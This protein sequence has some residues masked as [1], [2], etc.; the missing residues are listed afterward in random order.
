M[1][2]FHLFFGY[3]YPM[4]FRKMPIGIQDFE[5]IR[6]EGFV[7]ADKTAYV[8]RLA[9]ERKPYFLSRP[10]RFGKSLLV[11]TFKAYFEGKREIFE[12]IAGQPKLALA[13]LEQDWKPYPVFHLD[14]T[15]EA[16]QST[17]SLDSRLGSNL[18]LME[19][20]W[21]KDAAA[22]RFIGLIRRAYEKTN[23]PV[24]VLIDEYD[25]PLTDT[26]GTPEL[27]RE[28]RERIQGF[29]SVLKAAD[30]WLRFVFL[31]GVTKFSKV[32]IFIT[33]NQAPG[34]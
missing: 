8:H 3:T 20:K 19:E 12:A 26:L 33:L 5:Y 27:H 7:Y 29:Y 14:L 25:K 6:R 4:T 21:G 22:A 1:A 2:G 13:D 16:Y 15:G 9:G 18:R 10:R 30:Q 28:V 23:T 11:S 31:T 24:V 32:S 17:A 34:H